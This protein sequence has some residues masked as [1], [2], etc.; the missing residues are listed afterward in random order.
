MAYDPLKYVTSKAGMA[1]ILD[2][3]WTSVNNLAKRFAEMICI[4][5]GTKQ[6][7]KTG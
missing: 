6:G 2:A 3:D 1:W 4:M 7:G 5:E